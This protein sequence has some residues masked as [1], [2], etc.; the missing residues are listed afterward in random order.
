M[1]ICITGTLA[2]GAAIVSPSFHRPPTT[3][4]TNLTSLDIDYV[5]EGKTYQGYLSY[6]IPTLGQ[7]VLIAH[8]YMG[9]GEY[10]KARA[11]EMAKMVRSF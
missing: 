7:G 9:L 3:F 10:E 1:I 8:Q 4:D 2:H 11:D 5:V 6:G